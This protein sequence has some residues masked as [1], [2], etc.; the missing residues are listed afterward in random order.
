MTPEDG[1]ARNLMDYGVALG[2][3]F[4]SLKLWFVLRWFGKRGIAALIEDHVD[5]AAAFADRIDAAAEWERVAPTPMSTVLFRHRPASIGSDEPGLRAHNEAILHRMN[6]EGPAFLSH[7][8]VRGR[9]A[10]R[11]AVGNARTRGEHL[12]ALFAQLARVAGEV[13]AAS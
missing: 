10:L 5:L 6:D 7:T 12:D 2:R 8:I 9:Y 4:R 13:D 11:V 1:V 3:R